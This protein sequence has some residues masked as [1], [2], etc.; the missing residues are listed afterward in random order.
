LSIPYI[1]T[2]YFLPVFGLKSI[3]LIGTRN[4]LMFAMH[5]SPPPPFRLGGI[6]N[7]L[8]LFPNPKLQSDVSSSKV[9]FRSVP[10]RNIIPPD[11]YPL[12]FLSP[13]LVAENYDFSA[14]FHPFLLL[15]DGMLYVLDVLFV[16]SSFEHPLSAFSRGPVLH[17]VGGQTR[18]LSLHP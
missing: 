9:R 5:N 3:L 7:F 18:H 12:P 11:H 1:N 6:F 8:F 13:T 16:L 17:S 14:R 4:W 15:Y 10:A 2:I